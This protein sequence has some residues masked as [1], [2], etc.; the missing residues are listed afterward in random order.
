VKLVTTSDLTL[1][2][3]K[4]TLW[5]PSNAT[6]RVGSLELAE[7]ERPRRLVGNLIVADVAVSL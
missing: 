4:T 5:H 7:E 3:V 1:S 6:L 2:N